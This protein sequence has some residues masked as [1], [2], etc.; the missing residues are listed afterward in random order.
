[1]CGFQFNAALGKLANS[2]NSKVEGGYDI[3]SR[4]LALYGLQNSLLFSDVALQRFFFS[5]IEAR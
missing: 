5:G 1:V 2:A 4:F 3:E